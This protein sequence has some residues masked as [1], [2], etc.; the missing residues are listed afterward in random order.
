MQSKFKSS[1]DRT[2]RLSIITPTLNRNFIFQAWESLEKQTCKDFE[3][4]I[5][6]NGSTP[7][8]WLDLTKIRNSASFNVILTKE[9]QRGPAAAR[10]KGENIAT[11]NYISYLDDDDLYSNDVVES[12]LSDFSKNDSD[13][14][15]LKDCKLFF[16][17][18]FFRIY[19]PN[20][21]NNRLE[22]LLNKT[23]QIKL[24]FTH[25]FVR[26]AYKKS[27]SEK[28]GSWNPT[29]TS[30]ED[31]EYTLKIFLSEPKLTIAKGGTYYIRRENIVKYENKEAFE[32]VLNSYKHILK[33]V[34]GHKCEQDVK[35]RLAQDAKIKWEKVS[36]LFPD[37]GEK[38][39]EFVSS[40]GLQ[41]TK[42]LLIRK[43]TR[44]IKTPF[45]RIALLGELFCYISM[46]IK[47]YK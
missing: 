2:V 41:C 19:I 37:I 47:R 8:H 21:N 32:S 20:E 7:K 22:C 38:Y 44:L 10:R 45:R 14:S 27:L 28:S 13:I 36:L 12:W 33:Y 34:R 9:S 35:K 17:I 25:S 16:D 26:F 40:N 42:P 39:A 29:L 3:W 23:E 4:I 46:L 1:E 6:D 43:I 30:R 24:P 31:I 11:G 18:Y 15:L 5:I